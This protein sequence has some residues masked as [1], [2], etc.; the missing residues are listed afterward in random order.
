MCVSWHRNLLYT[1][2]GGTQPAWLL[3]GCPPDGGVRDDVMM[4][5][6]SQET[7]NKGCM[8]VLLCIWWVV[9]EGLCVDM[10]TSATF[11]LSFE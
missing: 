9:R 4:P 6:G 5:A 7:S 1:V 2:I 10:K 11:L 8:A 3:D